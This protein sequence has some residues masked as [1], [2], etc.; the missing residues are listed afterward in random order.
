MT[1]LG[2]ALVVLLLGL[3]PGLLIAG[4]LRADG[5]KPVPRRI[6][7][8]Y[9]AREEQKLRL[10]RIH[11]MAEMPLNH[12]G[13]TVD[14]WDVA[15]GLPNL[16][17]YPDLRGVLTWFATDPFDDPRAYTAWIGDAMDRG[18][19]VV[20][21]GQSGVR[22]SRG[23]TA[24]P[25]SLANRFYGRFGLRDD[26]GYSD[27]T[28]RSRPVVADGM[29]GFERPIDGP[30]P[31]YPLLRVVDPRVTSH[32]VVRRGGR[33]DSDS[34]LV[35]TGPTGGMALEGYVRHYDP[36]LVRRQW[37]IDP[38]AFFRAA[39]ATDDLPKPDVT[40]VSGR[41]LYFSH[42]DG[43]G[44][45]NLTEIESLAKDRLIAADVVR[46]EA[47]EPY[48]D[49]PVTVAPIVADLDPAWKGTPASLAAARA[50][51]ALPQVEPGSHTWTHPFFWGFYQDYT[52]EKEAVFVSSA[53]SGGQ[54]GPLSRW[55]GRGGPKE[56]EVVGEGGHA[57]GPDIGRYAVPRAFLQEPFSVA[58]EVGG[59]LDY[60]TGLAPAGKA[61]RLIQWSG[62][63][64]PFAEAIA[65]ARSAG[66]R[67]INGGDTRFDAEYPSYTAVAPIGVAMGDQR[68]IYAAASNENTYTDLW[69]NRFYGFRNL[70]HTM[71]NTETPIRVKPFNI[72]YHMYSGQKAASLA[73]LKDNLEAARA[74]EIAPVTAGH[75]AAIADGFYTVRMLADG[76]RRWR[77]L[78]RGAL[79]TLR[80]DGAG[81]DA[82]DFP[83][84]TGV[85]GQRHHQGSLYV[86]LDPAVAEPVVA[87]TTVSRTD[88]DP[89][90]PRPYLVEG[91]W[92]LE[93]VEAGES[94][95][96]AVA[97]GFGAGAMTWRVPMPGRY[98]VTAERS[99]RSLWRGEAVV[100]S[101][102]RLAFTVPVA[103]E[104]PL[105]IVAERRG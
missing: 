43:D 39:F 9:D 10:S 19:R 77:V 29:V 8:L 27:L 1:G 58:Q 104:T 20:V 60:M 79:A 16:A 105:R 70:V 33:A 51:F 100:G 42:I 37:I 65:A 38:F 23:G 21:F 4:P 25:M 56:D 82:V 102:H 49:L 24:M 34:H 17:R 64:Q 98:T 57:G 35:V 73:A 90:A 93:A 76:L 74:A 91:R 18:L 15:D 36:E 55:L 50:L 85:V 5:T 62:D 71:R 89:P 86:A 2:R 99:G 11:T 101:D 45:R 80:F 14:Y 52:P 48:P 3:L 84:S 12:L 83:R 88:V 44:W 6:L 46:R 97:K 72:Y 30:L 59:S 31:G 26:D 61:A 53:G 103:A 78:D 96:R 41:R 32:L 81:F 63:T 67:N 54:G 75:Y 69:T 13:L 92:V 40:T 22:R 95:F 87:L 68:Q 94:G 66:A 47:I 28:H 7:A